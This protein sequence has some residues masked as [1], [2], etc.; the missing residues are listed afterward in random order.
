MIDQPLDRIPLW[1]FFFVA[2]ASAVLAL[3]AGYR[4][5][6]FR[7]ARAAD[8]K[9]APVGAMVGSILGLVAIILAFTFNLAA[10]RFEARRQAI[11]EE[12]NAIGTCYLRAHI[13]PEPQRSEI[14]GLLRDYVEIRIKSRDV[15]TVSEGI[16]KSEELHSQLWSRAV[17]V[18]E[19][20]PT[21]IMTGLFL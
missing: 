1:S 8:E 2:T 7:R 18:A 17:V 9:E 19:K 20:T 21:S 16:K 14:E 15:Q 5:G 12:S 10:T 11:L 6:L 13:L 3:E 4:L